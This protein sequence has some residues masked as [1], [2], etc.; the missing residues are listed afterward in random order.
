M[1]KIEWFDISL[2][3]NKTIVDIFIE[4]VAHK[5][6]RLNNARLTYEYNGQVLMSAELKYINSMNIEIKTSSFT[7]TVPDDVDD[8]VNKL[9]IS[10]DNETRSKVISNM[11]E[12]IERLRS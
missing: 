1:S 6:V 5:L 4:D 9:H 7:I 8:M 12:Y 3:K 10:F 2:L 11:D